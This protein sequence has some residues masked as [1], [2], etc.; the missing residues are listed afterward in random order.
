MEM[1]RCVACGSTPIEGGTCRS[2]GFAPQM[3]DGFPAFAPDL[4][5]GN[6]GYDPVHHHTLA[7]LEDRNFWF[8]GR[9]RLIVA[10]AKRYAPRL[11]TFLE[12]GCGTGFVL[13]GIQSAFPSAQVVGSELFT[14]GLQHASR[15]L[16]KAHFIQMDARALP[17]SRT[18]DA[19][20]AFD[21]IEHIE[22]DN[23]VL[24][25]INQA[26]VEDGTLLLTVPQHRWL[27][28]EQDEI[29]HHVRRYSRRELVERVQAA[30]FDILKVSSFVTLLLPLMLLSRKRKRK[31]SVRDDPFLEFRIPRWLDSMFFLA[32]RVEASLINI[33][34]SL[35]VG[36]SLLLV[37]R[38]RSS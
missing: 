6:E 23:R 20:G 34:F 5:G 2:C 33:G 11:R 15:R 36:G 16:P 19:I 18:F 13:N 24:Q 31:V 32:M 14:S 26:L 30:G 29:A 27:W 17:Y 4:A 8:R 9:N 1:N 3:I 10:A 35:P 21:V 7:A 12:I 37:A 38:K 22:D 25:Q 28:S